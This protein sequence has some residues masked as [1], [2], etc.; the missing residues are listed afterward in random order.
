MKDGQAVKIFLLLVIEPLVYAGLLGYGTG[1]GSC[2]AYPFRC[3]ASYFNWTRR[4]F[5]FSRAHTVKWKYGC[6][7]SA[8][9]CSE[10]GYCRPLVSPSTS[11]SPCIDTSCSSSGST[12]TSATAT[13]SAMEPHFL[14]K[15]SWQRSRRV[16]TM[17]SL[18]ARSV[19]LQMSLCY[20]IMT[21]YMPAM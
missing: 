1:E 6:P 21:L 15:L 7:P 18:P 12:A 20:I 9:C 19:H 13:E 2:A 11:S 17:E 5:N 10:F 3:H 4:P 16:L 14:L 8:P